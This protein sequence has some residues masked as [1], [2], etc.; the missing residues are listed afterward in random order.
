MNRRRDSSIQK[1][2]LGGNKLSFTQLEIMP[3]LRGRSHFGAAKARSASCLPA[4][5]RVATTRISNGVY[6]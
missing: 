4:G 6:E 2:I 5:R 1:L 3:R